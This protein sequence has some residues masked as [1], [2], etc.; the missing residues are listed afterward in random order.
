[1]CFFNSS[2]FVGEDELGNRYYIRRDKRYV[3]YGG[4]PDATKISPLW[5][6]WLH[7][8]SD[9]PSELLRCSWQKLRKPNLT[10]TSMAYFPSFVKKSKNDSL[11]EKWVP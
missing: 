10:G 9:A 3:V 5:H 11:Y 2:R 7:Y 8:A 4:C 6:L 1:M